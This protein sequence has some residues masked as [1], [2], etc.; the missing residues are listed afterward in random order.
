[1]DEL[2]SR[3]LDAHGELGYCAG[4]SRQTPEMSLA[5]ADVSGVRSSTR[6]TALI[7]GASRGIGA[8][9]Q[10]VKGSHVAFISQPEIATASILKAVA[11]SEDE[12]V[13]AQ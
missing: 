3:A 12:K 13:V 9:S 4:L 1:M 6:G 5:F 10:S 8:V 2:L 11:A 7:T